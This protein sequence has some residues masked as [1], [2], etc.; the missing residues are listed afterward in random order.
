[1]RSQIKFGMH[2]EGK[3]YIDEQRS[4]ERGNSER[5]FYR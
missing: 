4:D 5:I 1:M 3:D 2:E